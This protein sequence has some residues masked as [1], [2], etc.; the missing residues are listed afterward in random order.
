MLYSLIADKITKLPPEIAFYISW[1]YFKLLHAFYILPAKDTIIII[2]MYYSHTFL[3]KY[4][5]TTVDL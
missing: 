1:I 4:D 5:F 2:T 3:K